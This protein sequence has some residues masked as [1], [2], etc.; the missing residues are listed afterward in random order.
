LHDD[1]IQ[2]IEEIYPEFLPVI[3][4]WKDWYTQLNPNQ[5]SRNCIASLVMETLAPSRLGLPLHSF[6]LL[7]DG[8]P[9]PRKSNEGFDLFVQRDVA[10]QSALET[11]CSDRNIEPGSQS[12]VGPRG[13]SSYIMTGFPQAIRDITAGKS[14]IKCNSD[15]GVAYIGQ[16]V[17]MGQTWRV[18]EWEGDWHDH[19]LRTFATEAPSLN[20]FDLRLHDNTQSSGVTWLIGQ[21]ILRERGEQ[22][23]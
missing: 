12:W 19:K 15:V 3:Q 8:E 11:W 10:W 6:D 18:D 4:H 14:L 7:I 16:L 21:P 20:R 5:V 22:R 23:T 1:I 2:N 17:H 13:N 9:M